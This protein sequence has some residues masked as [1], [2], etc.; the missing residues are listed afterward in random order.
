MPKALGLKEFLHP[1]QMV[2]AFLSLAKGRL[3]AAGSPLGFVQSLSAV[4]LLSEGSTVFFPL[5]SHLKCYL[6]FNLTRMT[7][8]MLNKYCSAPAVY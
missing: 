2:M 7:R 1:F 8:R 4:P 3:Q 5:L 6:N